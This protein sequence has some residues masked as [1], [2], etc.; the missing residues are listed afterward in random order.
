MEGVQMFVISRV[1]DSDQES[2]SETEKRYEPRSSIPQFK[3]F[4]DRNRVILAGGGVR[5]SVAEHS[6][7]S[8]CHPRFLRRGRSQEPSLQNQ[9]CSEGKSLNRCN[10]KVIE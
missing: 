1:A 4:P 5:A 2:G 9:S 6:S 10:R 7:A 8:F 3:S